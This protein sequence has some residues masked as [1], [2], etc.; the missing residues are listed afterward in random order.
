MSIREIGTALRRGIC[1]AARNNCLVYH[2][3]RGLCV[4]YS[5]NGQLLR[6]RG[7]GRGSRSESGLYRV[8]QKMVYFLIYFII[9][10]IS[11]EWYKKKKMIFISTYTRV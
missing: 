11:P 8:F 6:C 4:I 7:A 1:S 10:A 9:V 2:G 5:R 3:D